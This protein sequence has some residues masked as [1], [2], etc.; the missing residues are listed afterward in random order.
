[1]NTSDGQQPHSNRK[2]WNYQNRSFPTDKYGIS[3]KN[4]D[5]NKSNIDKYQKKYDSSFSCNWAIAIFSFGIE[6][7]GV[8]KRKHQ[9]RKDEALKKLN[10][11]KGKGRSIIDLRTNKNSNKLF[12]IS[13]NKKVNNLRLYPSWVGSGHEST[14]LGFSSI[15]VY[16]S[17]K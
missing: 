3:L 11:A 2:G 8:Q 4:Y 6:N 7:C 9:N 12:S 14:Y 13:G 10:E 17:L 5:L 16:E 15:I 1:M